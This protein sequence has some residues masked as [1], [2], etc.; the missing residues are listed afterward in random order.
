MRSPSV[1]HVLHFNLQRNQ[2]IF[3]TIYVAIENGLSIAW[4]SLTGSFECYD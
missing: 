1:T 4:R 2:N 3:K